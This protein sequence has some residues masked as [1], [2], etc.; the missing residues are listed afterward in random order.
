MYLLLCGSGIPDTDELHFFMLLL[1]YF[2]LSPP[3]KLFPPALFPPGLHLKD[4]KQVH[5]RGILLGPMHV[6]D[7]SKTELVFL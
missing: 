5:E 7:S 6:M 2:F 4:I 3:L 1:Y